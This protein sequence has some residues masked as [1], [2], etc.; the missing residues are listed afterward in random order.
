VGK[1]VHL[2]GIAFRVETQTLGSA[3]GTV[4]DA[5]TGAPLDGGEI[6][7][8]VA[9]NFTPIEARSRRKLNEGA[10]QFDL[11]ARGSYQIF[12]FRQ[13]GIST[14][15]FTYPLEISGADL[16][17]LRV[18][19]PSGGRV[20]GKITGPRNP[21]LTSVSFL[22]SESYTSAAAPIA[23]DGSFV[24][25]GLAPG[26]WNI[27]FLGRTGGTPTTVVSVLQAG[28]RIAPLTV[29][30]GDNPP[31]E[32]VVTRMFWVI[33]VIRDQA[34]KPVENAYVV[35]QYGDGLR[36]MQAGPDGGYATGLPGG[37][38]LLTAWRRMPTPALAKSCPTA[39]PVQIKE[40]VAGLD[41]I[42]CQ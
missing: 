1:G 19:L 23:D 35:F 34:G 37:D 32:I 11:L 6:E 38:F 4:I 31:L 20:S 36:S 13:A 26:K 12:V 18:V 2:T 8:R 41:A 27:G 39:R 29:I 24:I 10:F 3:G 16:A 15:A 5:K 17:G 22:S 7:L 28:K 40:D 9:G 33:G 21:L 25:E 42:L 14:L 30:E